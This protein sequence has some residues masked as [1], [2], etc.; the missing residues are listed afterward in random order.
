MSWNIQSLSNELKANFSRSTG[1]DILA[2]Q[3]IWNP[4]EELLS[5]YKDY[6]M[7]TRSK[8]RGGGTMISVENERHFIAKS[9][10][11]NEDMEIHKVILYE[12]RYIWLVSVYLP[13]GTKAQLQR[14]FQEI[15]RVVPPSELANLCM[16]G[17]WNIDQ[18]TDNEMK[19]LL[20]KLAK[21]LKLTIVTPSE[22]MRGRNLLDY[23]LT[24]SAIVETKLECHNAPSDHKYI[25][26]RM[27]VN[28][29]KAKQP[30]RLPNKKAASRITLQALESATMSLDF[31]QKHAALST[32]EPSLQCVRQR[33]YR[34]DILSSI[35]LNEEVEDIKKEIERY[36][37]AQIGVNELQRFSA[38]QKLAFQFLKKVF[39]YNSYENSRREYCS[40]TDR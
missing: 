9:I 17:D 24:G 22:T 28:T 6:R 14:L 4:R 32:G 37:N 31:L 30:L 26:L 1:A 18:N 10:P 38:D 40:C 7:I 5:I 39:K 21:Q 36:W 20:I 12:E 11:L 8:K 34:N 29:T 33:Q 16:V 25:L 2:L 13:K 23:A 35:L 27:N 19:Q 3:E 15:L